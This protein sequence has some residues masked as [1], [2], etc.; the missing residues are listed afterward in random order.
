RSPAIR[1]RPCANTS[2]MPDDEQNSQ[3]Y[4]IGAPAKA[5]H[6]DLWPSSK[7]SGVP[8]GMRQD[9]ASMLQNIQFYSSAA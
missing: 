8:C 3:G 7:S 1:Y 2:S 5:V 6:L 9:V 4:R